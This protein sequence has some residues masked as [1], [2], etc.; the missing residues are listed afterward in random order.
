MIHVYSQIILLPVPLCGAGAPCDLKFLA[1]YLS[2]SLSFAL[3]W[4]LTLTDPAAALA[5]EVHAEFEY[6]GL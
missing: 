6:L 4:T 1:H 5:I 2:S 3:T